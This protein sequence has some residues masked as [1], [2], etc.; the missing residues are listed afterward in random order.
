[1]PLYVEAAKVPV[2]TVDMRTSTFETR[3]VY[4]TEGSL[5]VATRPPAYHSPPHEHDCEQ[6]N[7]MQDGELWIFIEHRAYL[8]RPGDFLR[9]PPG[10]PHW[11]WNK[12][13]RTCTLIEMHAPG[14]QDDPVIRAASVPLFEDSESR[15]TT[16]TPHNRFVDYDTKPAERLIEAPLR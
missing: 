2:H 3:L 11:S 6:L 14:L 5:M 16:G 4:G 8:L 15:R 1:M 12:T 7:Y 9:I 13:D 10:L